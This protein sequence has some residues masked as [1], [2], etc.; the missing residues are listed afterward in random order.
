MKPGALTKITKESEFKSKAQRRK[1]YALKD[2]GEMTQSK[3]DEWEAD[4]PKNIPE[5][6][7]KKD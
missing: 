5:R 1:F 2:R 6:V 4:T 7:P 3:I